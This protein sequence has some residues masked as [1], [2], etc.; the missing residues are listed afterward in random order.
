MLVVR[1]GLG[2]GPQGSGRRRGIP[3]SAQ[4][5]R[6]LREGVGVGGRGRGNGSRGVDTKDGSRGRLSLQPAGWSVR[7]GEGRALDSGGSCLIRR[8]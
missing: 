4:P 1:A 5:A 2:K 3:F 7:D 6:C 8:L